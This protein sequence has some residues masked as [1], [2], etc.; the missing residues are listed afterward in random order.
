MTVTGRDNDG[1]PL[2]D[3]TPEGWGRLVDNLGPATMLV[4]IENRMGTE[5]RQRLTAEDIWQETLLHV[6]RDRATVPWQGY[7]AFR[8]FVLAVAEN[9]IRNAADHEGASKR[10]G[11]ARD[12]P[13][14]DANASEWSRSDGPPAVASTTPS[15]IAALREEAESMRQALASLP[16]DL[17]EVL[18]LRLF[19]E[20][21]VQEVAAR[22]GLGESA[23]KHRFRR[24]AGLYQ[25]RL[26]ARLG[27]G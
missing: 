9:R 6:W 3:P 24:A 18:R 12:M 25:A 7:P 15:R 21:P 4:C 5:L 20:M 11:N 16:E 13:L 1:N 22:L 27:G 17:R 14:A 8:R 2:L 19:E 10:R 23:V 26:R